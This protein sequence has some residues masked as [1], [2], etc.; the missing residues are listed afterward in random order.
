MNQ[1][2]L[3]VRDEVLA[4]IGLPPGDLPHEL[5]PVAIG[6]LAGEALDDRQVRFYHLW[7]RLKHFRPGDLAPDEAM[8]RDRLAEH[9]EA[10]L[11]NLHGYVRQA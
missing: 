7:E 1:K 11:A 6:D 9:V 3:R 10:I 8:A 2:F 5:P 4:E